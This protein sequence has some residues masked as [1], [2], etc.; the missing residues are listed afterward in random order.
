MSEILWSNKAARNYDDFS[1]R[2]TT[3]FKRYNL[4]KVD[5]SKQFFKDMGTAGRNK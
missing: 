1:K 4:W 5:Y 3:Q 2:L